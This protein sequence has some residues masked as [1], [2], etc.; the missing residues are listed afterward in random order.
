MKPKYEEINEILKKEIKENKIMFLSEREIIHRFN[1]SSITAR[2]VLNELEEEGY[3]ERRAGKGSIVIKKVN[4]IGII[5]YNIRE[6]FSSFI[7]E[8]IEGIEEEAERNGYYIHLYTTKK[9]S[10]IQTKCILYNLI[11]KKRIGGVL[12]LSPLPVEDIRFLKEKGIPFVVIANYY[13]DIECSYVIYDYKGITKKICRMLYKEGKRRIGILISQKGEYGAKRSG[14]LIYDG[15][16][17]FLKEEGINE[18]VVV[19][20]KGKVDM[21]ELIDLMKRVDVMIV[22]STSVSD[23]ILERGLK[24]NFILYTHQNIDDPQVI[25]FPL[26]DY[27]RIGFEI[28]DRLIKGEKEDIKVILKPE[29]KREIVIDKII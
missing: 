27:G 5:S 24:G 20:I 2:R 28:L 29:I 4:E 6:A 25:Y 13:P 22:G 1:V 14:D 8:I 9:R 7:P 26:K 17:E 11:N 23:N 15:Y 21:K 12:I 16:E 19:E 3:I 18:R 10:I